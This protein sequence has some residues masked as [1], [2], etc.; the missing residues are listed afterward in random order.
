MASTLPLPIRIAAGLIAS[1]LDHLRRLPEELPAL[2]VTLAG[3]AVRASMR[4]QQELAEL[5]NRGDELLSP[6]VDRPEEHP[7]WAQ[8]DDQQHDD[9]QF[10]DPQFDD[11]AMA[12]ESARAVFDPEPTAAGESAPDAGGVENYVTGDDLGGDL[13]GERAGGDDVVPGAAARD[14][15]LGPAPLPGYA[16][17]RATQVRAR[18]RG[19]TA[20]EVED[21]LDYE[22]S[23]GG[24]AAF[25]T[26]LENRLATVRAGGSTDTDPRGDSHGAPA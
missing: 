20:E 6:I 16:G 5:A 3:Q 18:L 1:G 23:H 7:A 11:T 26:L 25:L 14:D 2:S 12:D 17:L 10:D 13:E 22:R 21:V 9:P 19:L 15:Q 8:F 4:V 24:R